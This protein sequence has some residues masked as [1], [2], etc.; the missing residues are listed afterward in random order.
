LDQE[1]AGEAEDF[2]GAKIDERTRDFSGLGAKSCNF[3]AGWLL[4]EARLKWVNTG[5][6]P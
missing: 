2:R 1:V 5:L 3:R 6:S 4:A